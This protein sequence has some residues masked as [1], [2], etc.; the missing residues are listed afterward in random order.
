ML[1]EISIVLASGRSNGGNALREAA[2]AYKVNTDAITLKVK[3]EFAAKEKAKKESKPIPS[4]GTK[5]RKA[6]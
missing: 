2:A 3:Q 6:A 1:V 4:G 5:S